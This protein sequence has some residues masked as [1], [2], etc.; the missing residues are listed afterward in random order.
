VIKQNKS[1][2]NK[3]K[4]TNKK[5]QTNQQGEIFKQTRNKQTNKQ[6]NKTSRFRINGISDLV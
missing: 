6:I 5:P 1:T 2:K 3:S 4:Q